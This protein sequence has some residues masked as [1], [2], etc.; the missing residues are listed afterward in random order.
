MRFFFCRGL[1]IF[2]ALSGFAAHWPDRPE[3]ACH[4][5]HSMCVSV[6]DS[7][8]Q[9]Y[10]ADM[11]WNT[12][13]ERMQLMQQYSEK[14]WCCTY[15]WGSSH[16]TR[17]NC[18]RMHV[19]LS[20]NQVKIVQQI[21]QAGRSKAPIKLLNKT[22][23]IKWSAAPMEDDLGQ[24]L[25]LFECL[26]QKDA[27]PYL[28]KD[29][30]KRWY[31]SYAQRR[32][33]CLEP[34]LV[35]GNGVHWQG[36]GLWFHPAL[37]P[38]PASSAH[39]FF[40]GISVD[41]V[42]SP[43]IFL[44]Q[45][46]WNVL[47][48]GKM[49]SVMNAQKV[50]RTKKVKAHDG[51]EF[52][53]FLPSSYDRSCRR[54]ALL[55]L[56]CNNSDSPW[57]RYNIFAKHLGVVP[58]N[59]G[60][61][62]D[63]RTLFDIY[64]REG[65][66]GF[67]TLNSI[68][69]FSVGVCF[70]EVGDETCVSLFVRPGSFQNTEN[71]GSWVTP[72]ASIRRCESAEHYIVG[73][74]L[75]F[76][77]NVAPNIM[78][79]AEVVM[80]DYKSSFAFFNTYD[81]EGEGVVFWFPSGAQLRYEVVCNLNKWKKIQSRNVA[82]PNINNAVWMNE[83]DLKGAGIGLL[84]G[85]LRQEAQKVRSAGGVKRKRVS[86]NLDQSLLQYHLQI[87]PKKV[88]SA[89]E[90]AVI[91]KVS[92]QAVAKWSSQKDVS[93]LCDAVGG[94]G[95][96]NRDTLP[97]A[98][99]KGLITEEKSRAQDVAAADKALVGQTR[100]ILVKSIPINTFGTNLVLPP[101][102]MTPADDAET[103]FFY[104]HFLKGDAHATVNAVHIGGGCVNKMPLQIKVFIPDGT[105]QGATKIYS[106][107][108]HVRFQMAPKAIIE[109]K[110]GTITVGSRRI[111]QALCVAR[112]LPGLV[113]LQP[114]A[115]LGDRAGAWRHCDAEL[116][117]DFVLVRNDFCQNS[118]NWRRSDYIRWSDLPV[119]QWVIENVDAGSVLNCRIVWRSKDPLDLCY[120]YYQE[121]AGTESVLTHYGRLW[122]VKA[123]KALMWVSASN[124]LLQATR[125]TG[126]LDLSGQP[127]EVLLSHI[128]ECPVESLADGDGKIKFSYGEGKMFALTANDPDDALQISNLWLHDGEH[129]MPLCNAQAPWTTAC[130]TV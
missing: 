1:M 72:T 78:V 68:K 24:V 5:S 27:H 125:T 85:P 113:S 35:G 120:M 38:K 49:F 124:D 98:V 97:L 56:H 76:R 46:G 3:W 79:A 112:G 50:S 92:G 53:S 91:Q 55:R 16:Y 29:E 20:D 115:Q 108:S 71:I 95:A 21:S 42:V 52:R 110:N 116:G 33:M 70:R 36:R 6:G 15:Y 26:A 34:K 106:E 87:C 107:R 88:K 47:A 102:M 77:V 100:G 4:L 65:S 104:Y 93:A 118:T 10:P 121:S 22:I 103:L 69:K 7:V 2:F 61:S 11:A 41:R 17:P 30:S 48:E 101:V 83:E 25:G 60:E 43:P 58:V 130:I 117:E 82:K 13:G 80:Q 28:E 123:S 109:C 75:G 86:Q 14:H 126:K 37:W 19:L 63:C 129:S 12:F 74:R 119:V 62:G 96:E 18:L 127:V 51:M 45:Y 122:W 40:Q 66:T 64:E 90:D 94:Q 67:V 44:N 89:D 128:A 9:L 8:N 111:R 54:G 32:V 39:P 114:V 99:L 73:E 105:I 57:L 59:D 23:I 81:D 31:I 84:Q